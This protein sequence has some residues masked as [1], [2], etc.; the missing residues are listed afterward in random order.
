METVVVALVVGAFGGL[1]GSIAG[2]WLTHR[3]SRRRRR[4]EREEERNQELRRML[5]ALMRLIHTASFTT[6]EIQYSDIVGESLESVV[7]RHRQYVTDLHTRHRDWIW[8]PHRIHD[9][10]LRRLAIGFNLAGGQLQ[11]LVGERSGFAS[12]YGSISTWSERAQ[13]VRR[14]VDMLE[15]AVDKRMDELGW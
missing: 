6:L 5:E 8:Q 12:P 15:E 14:W 4:E 9:E 11:L 7:E 13:N 2:P 1:L 10:T 3:L